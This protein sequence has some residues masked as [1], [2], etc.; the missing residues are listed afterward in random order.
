MNSMLY[1]DKC[2]YSSNCKVPVQAELLLL[3]AKYT[4]PFSKSDY[5]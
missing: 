2:G 5:N 4:P 1:V 3:I